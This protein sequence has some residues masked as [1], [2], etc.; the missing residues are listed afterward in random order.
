MPLLVNISM[1][2]VWI[3]CIFML[4][5]TET[6]CVYVSTCKHQP[7]HGW[8]DSKI[9]SEVKIFVSVVKLHAEKQTEFQVG[10]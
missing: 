4:N 2:Q 6:G 5:G 1:K 10:I 8:L 7:V 9:H 3:M